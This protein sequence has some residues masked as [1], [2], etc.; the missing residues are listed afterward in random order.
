MDLERRVEVVE[1]LLH[2]HHSPQLMRQR[3]AKVAREFGGLEMVGVM[4]VAD[5]SVL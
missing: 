4:A 3:K 2:Q 1:K 5:L